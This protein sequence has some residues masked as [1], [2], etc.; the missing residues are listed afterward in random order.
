MHHLTR[1]PDLF[2]RPI[3]WETTWEDFAARFL[4]PP[5]STWDKKAVPLWSPARYVPGAP[6]KDLRY[7]D[8]VSMFVCDVDHAP[9][10]TLDV[11]RARLDALGCAYAIVSSYGDSA[12]SRSGHT[13]FRVVVPLAEPVPR[14]KWAE[15][16]SRCILATCPEFAD[17]Q[18]KDASH[19]Y[20]VPSC[21][22]Q[23]TWP[24]GWTPVSR[25]G[26]GPKLNPWALPERPP[27]AET[28][29]TRSATYD[30]LE[31]I[32]KKWAKSTKAPKLHMARCLASLIN[33]EPFAAE[34]ER[35]T[36]T[37]DLCRELAREL[38]DCTA[39]SLALLF[40]P[41]LSRMGTGAPTVTACEDKIDKAFRWLGEKKKAASTA[42]GL[43]WIVVSSAG[44]AYWIR[45][46]DGWH[47]PYSGDAVDMALTVHLSHAV[48]IGDVD[49]MTITETGA[50][51]PKTRS[52]LTQ[53]YGLPVDSLEAQMGID[54]STVEISPTGRIRMIEA[55]AT[56]KDR[57]PTFDPI[58]DEFLRRLAGPKIADLNLW[59]SVVP[60]LTEPLA[61]MVL[62]GRKGAGKSLLA[63]GLSGI[64]S[65][66]GPTPAGSALAEWNSAILT[67]P[68]V[69]ADEALPSLRTGENPT[70]VLREKIQARVHVIKRKYLPDT[71]ATGSI[72]ILVAANNDRII[73]FDS[74]LSPEDLAALSE[75]F[76]QLTVDPRCA[77]WLASDLSLGPRILSR[78][79]GHC[80]YLNR[81]L[82]REKQ[83][84]FWLKGTEALTRA[85]SIRG[86]VRSELCRYV[87]EWLARPEL[88]SGEP[89]ASKVEAGQILISTRDVDRTWK[90]ILP[91]SLPPPLHALNEALRILT[92]ETKRTSSYR[93]RVIDRTKIQEWINEV[94]WPVDLRH[95]IAD[96]ERANAKRTRNK[97]NRD[98]HGQVPKADGEPSDGG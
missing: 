85:L 18:C 43:P 95:L 8:S 73:N 29:A 80:W 30:D 56:P 92:L 27:G 24:D 54:R 7:V 84:R 31:A 13:K 1:L 22:P 39:R 50:V 36:A 83:H 14:S 93:W 96:W 55:H 88:T 64:W 69:F 49:L 37:F 19:A 6:G 15:V 75:R 16:W 3:P 33:G 52:Q 45:S 23:E 21:P 53:H 28:K 91:E 67:C 20:F 94:D 12:A 46:L 61:A 32:R 48:S 90:R 82:Y 97:S 70:A 86:G 44:S 74:V 78:L 71:T 42:D 17:P 9:S 66:T 77:D 26:T 35:D 40:G 51:A 79:P 34:G 41:S 65:D 57:T 10:R 58:V 11:V 60:D 63:M 76:Y 87:V 4:A 98:D 81:Y 68:L 47:G 89:G 72:R 2:A 38:G 59:L 62:T 5:L 25:S